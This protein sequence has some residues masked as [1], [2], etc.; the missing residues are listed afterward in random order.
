MIRQNYIPTPQILFVEILTPGTSEYDYIWRQHLL[1]GNEGKLS[2]YGWDLIRYDW[3]PYEKKRLGYQMTQRKDH[4]KTL[5]E[6][7]HL[8]AKER[9]LRRSQ[10]D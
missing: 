4:V 3:C 1:K 7:R 10:L 2:S 9:G 5:E 8:Q 6:D